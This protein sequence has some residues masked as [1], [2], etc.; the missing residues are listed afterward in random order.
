MEVYNE[1]NYRNIF[2]L[3]PIV[4]D[5]TIKVTNADTNIPLSEATVNYNVG[6][7]NQDGETEN[8]GT[9]GLGIQRVGSNFEVMVEKQCYHTLTVTNTV[10]ETCPYP[11][12]LEMSQKSKY[13]SY[14]L[15]LLSASQMP[16]RILESDCIYLPSA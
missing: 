10:A 11:L 8:D 12:T 15:F 1:H 7:G 13:T 4:C 14:L 5:T 9:I 16:I 3:L 6:L 2:L